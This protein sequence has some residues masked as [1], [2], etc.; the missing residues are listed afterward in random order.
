MANFQAYTF[1]NQE[2]NTHLTKFISMIFSELKLDTRSTKKDGSHPVKIY[3]RANNS[4]F[5]LNTNISITPETWDDINSTITSKNNKSIKRLLEVKQRQVNN[6]LEELLLS[7]KLRTMSTTEIS[8]AVMMR[9]AKK[10]KTNEVETAFLK[11]ID[12]KVKEKT[13]STYRDTLQILKKYSDI[14]SLQFNDIN[15]KFLSDLEIY[16][17]S[18]RGINGRSVVFRNIRAVYNEAIKCNIA[19]AEE[20]PFKLF[21]IKKEETQHRSL[22]IKELRKLKDY[23]LDDQQQKYVD[24]FFLSF[25]ML[26]INMVD[27]LFLKRE[28]LREDRIEYYRSKTNKFFSIKLEPEA[29][30]IIKKYEGVNYLINVMDRYNNYEYFIR[31]MNDCLKLIGTTHV[32]GCR[33]KGTP[34]FPFLSTYWAR[35]SWATM[36]A[37]LEI[38]ESVI[39]MALG[40]SSGN[41][42]TSIYIRPNQK[43]VDLA[44]RKVIDYLNSQDVIEWT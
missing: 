9:E 31:N 40:H 16:M 11:M 33:R 36:A 29:L 13:K 2:N 1:V 26:G 38:S 28:N 35:H 7:G 25:Y 43:K 20:N 24:I 8:D 17:S 6:I 32:N 34:L 39:A 5:R 10:S 19:K 30:S 27:L 22:T 42:V 18:T 44:N 4:N 12:S 37:D 23:K 14:S 15:Y 3:F 21:K 41:R